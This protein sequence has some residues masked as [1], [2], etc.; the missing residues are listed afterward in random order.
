MDFATMMATRR[1]CRAYQ[2]TPVPREMLLKIVEAGRLTP[3][4]CNAQPWKFIV[5]DEP[6]AKERLCDALVVENGHTG[7][8]WRKE[9]PAFI[10]LC[11]VEAKVMPAVISHYKTTQ[12]FAQGDIGAAAMNMCHQ[13]MELGLATCLLGINDQE[14]MERYFGIPSGT[15][16]RLILAVGYAAEKQPAFKKVRKPLEEVCSFNQW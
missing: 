2:E 4:G 15:E 1:S 6:Q 10:V 9:V 11:E 3:S 16:V 5:V 13:A 7:C 12:R 14:K 8:P